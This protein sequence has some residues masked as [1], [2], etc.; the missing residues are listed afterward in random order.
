MKNWRMRTWP[1]FFF[2]VIKISISQNGG[3]FIMA[4]PCLGELIVLT[5]PSPAN[6]RGPMELPLSSVK[7]VTTNKVD[8]SNKTFI[9]Y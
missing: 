2:F 6:H 3:D 5:N 1:P 7:L 4:K 8:I 9:E